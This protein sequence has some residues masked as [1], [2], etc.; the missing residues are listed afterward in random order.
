M[1]DLSNLIQVLGTFIGAAATLIAVMHKSHKE[2]TKDI[3]SNLK[4]ERD[5]FKQDYE[6]ERKKRLE[7][8][9][10]YEKLK[11]KTDK[12]KEY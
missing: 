7:I 12:L 10:K 6:N 11:A 2:D 5:D 3:I 9:E 8:G 1:H 4:N